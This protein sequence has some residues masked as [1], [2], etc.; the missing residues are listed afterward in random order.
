MGTR[1]RALRG[2]L[3]LDRAD[4]GPTH[5]L[6]SAQVATGRCVRLLTGHAAPVRDVTSSADGNLAASCDEDGRVLLWHLASG[7]VLHRLS[8]PAAGCNRR[9]REGHARAQGRSGAT[10]AVGARLLSSSLS[11]GR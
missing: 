8:A 5:G 10:A 3:H 4:R 9:R 7:R 6:H 2:P 1:T 11:P